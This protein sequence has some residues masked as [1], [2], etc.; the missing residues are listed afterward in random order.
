MNIEQQVTSL[1]LAKQLK[2]AGYPQDECLFY[3]VDSS[4]WWGANELPRLFMKGYVFNSTTFEVGKDCGIASP[5]V[6]EL[7]QQLQNYETRYSLD[8]P[9]PFF[10]K[11]QHIHYGEFRLTNIN[12]VTD[13]YDKK[14][15]NC[16]AK[17]WLDLRGKGI[18]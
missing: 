10:I 16:L 7:I 6:A 8:F 17:M 2:E 11:G 4:N 18:L 9:N 13:I 3:W 1:E 5:T 12:S 15:S 14:L